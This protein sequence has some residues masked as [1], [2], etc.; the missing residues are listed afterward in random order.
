MVLV[1]LFIERWFFLA[2]SPNSPNQL[3]RSPER[4]IISMMS[5][6]ECLVLIKIKNLIHIR[7]QRQKL[8]GDPKGAAD[9][10]RVATGLVFLWGAV[11]TT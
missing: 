3:G 9:D 5:L 4:I 2:L 8:G 10:P 1:P 7:F 6:T 11:P